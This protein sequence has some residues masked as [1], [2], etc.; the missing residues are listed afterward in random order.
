M[1][2][3]VFLIG[4]AIYVFCIIAHT[5]TSPDGNSDMT[6]LIDGQP[7]GSFSQSPTGAPNYDFGVPVYSNNSLPAGN[8]LFT[9]QNGHVNGLKSLVLLDY[10]IYS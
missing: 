10:I 7:V 6:F 2:S 4:T 3:R 9:L 5:F 1:L 8:H